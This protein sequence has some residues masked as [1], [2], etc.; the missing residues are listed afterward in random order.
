[1]NAWLDAGARRVRFNP[2][3][4]YVE[5]VMGTSPVRS[6]QNPAGQRLDR[7]TIAGLVEPEQANGGPSDAEGMAAAVSELADRT[8]QQLGASADDSSHPMTIA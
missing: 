6:V 7:S 2:D 1:V 8:P 4:H 3:A 5:S